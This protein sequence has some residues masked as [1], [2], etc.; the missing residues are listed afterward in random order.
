MA[1]TVEMSFDKFYE[2]INLDGD[3]REI[4]N[5]RRERVASLLS[6]HFEVLDTF[7]T[8]SIPKF[9]ALKDHA[10]L[11]VMVVLHYGKHIKGKIPEQVL[12]SVRDA[13]AEYRS[14]VRKNGQAVTLYYDSWPNVDIVPVSRSVN[15]KGEVT[16]Y[17]VPNM[18]TGQWIQ[19][20][21]KTHAREI[22]ARAGKCGTNFR[23]IIKMIKWWN[24]IHG[25]Y[26]QS[27]HIEVLALKVLG[28]DLSDTPWHA[29]RFFKSA[30]ELLGSR[31]RYGPGYADD[32]LDDM[33]RIEV[34]QRFDSAIDKSRSAWSRTYDGTH[35]HKGAIE[36]WRG[37]DL[38]GD[39]FPAYG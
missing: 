23:R 11:D 27:Y 10:D 6:K 3:H 8:G 18:N 20:K 16:H 30:R 9:T 26:L 19:A 38:F 15:D 33:D 21:P 12:Q 39:K 14:N 32:Y 34:I 25:D 31:L 28:S 17:N 1:Y 24:L 35:D 13:L 22:E 2:A 29:F 37:R 7:A 36:L 4:A 5:K